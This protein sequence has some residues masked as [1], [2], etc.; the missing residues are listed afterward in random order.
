MENNPKYPPVDKST[1]RYIAYQRRTNKT[2]LFITA[3]ILGAVILF[4]VF[5]MTGESHYEKGNAYL[6]NKQYTEALAEYEKIDPDEKDYPKVQSKINYINGLTSYNM[7]LYPA[8]LTYLSKVA[9]DDEYFHDAQLM[10]QNI[11]QTTEDQ[12]LKAQLDSLARLKKDTLVVKHET[13]TGTGTIPGVK[14]LPTDAELSRRYYAKLQNVISGFESNY[15]SAAV[16]P[17]NSKSDY[18]AKMQSFRRDLI[19]AAYEA[20]EKDPD[21]ISLRN[22]INT[23]MDKRISYIN[24]LISE[25][26]VTETNTS[27]SLK[28]EGD[29]L[30][31]QVRNQLNR[32]GGRY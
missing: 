3:L 5:T 28:E 19:N 11:N 1:Q 26:S 24:K 25:N 31:F 14:P 2:L 20:R 4:F 12:R 16:V 8:A 21:L 22:S 18:L 27:R 10:I 6:K 23:W 32:A 13:S 9:P 7:S 29:K 15:Q 17:V 30:Y